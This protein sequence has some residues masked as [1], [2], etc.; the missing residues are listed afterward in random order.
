MS[1]TAR[2]YPD[3]A[4]FK[5]L[6]KRGNAVPVYRQVL[7]DTLT[8]VSAFE[9]LAGDSPHAFL[10]ESVV[11]GEKIARYSFVGAEPYMVFRAR[12]EAVELERPGGEAERCTSSDPLALLQ[13]LVERHRLVAVPGLPRFCGGA[14]GFAAYDAVRYFEHL[15]T[16]PPDTLGLPD[17]SFALYNRMLVFDHIDKTVR[18]VAVAF[19]EDRDADAAYDEAVRAVD[20]MVEALRT[21]T[22]AH[23]EDV[24]VPR[25]VER[26]VTS[27][28]DRAGFEAAVR[29]AKEYIRAGDV[30]QV[31]L[32]QRFSTETTAS[33]LDIYRVLRVVNPSPFLFLVRQDAGSAGG[34]VHL[35]GSSPEVMVRVEGGV[36]T[37]R[38][39][40]GT[41]PRGR[42]PRED[43][44]LARE[45]LADP[46]ER[47]E[48]VMLLDLGRNDVGRVARPGTVR[49]DER[50]I[51]ERFS[52]VM[53]IT[54]NVSGLLADGRDAFDALRA[55]LPAGTVSGAP[56]VRAM[57]IIDEL[58]P[59]R[60]G[61][62]AGAV[63]Y[64][65]F[66]GN[67][68]TCIALRTIVMQGRTAH[69]Q[70]GAGIVADSV[71]AREYEE[72]LNKARALLVAIE[73]AESLGG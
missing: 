14:V 25:A 41:R 55:A 43:E 45:L 56:K 72:T 21:P 19:A 10:L 61:P 28:F 9:K 38:P 1:G 23:A 24:A 6:L 39:I 46:K 65:D 58:E 51:I 54:S 5:R 47:A 26:P 16:P 59:V 7:A 22:P 67:M 60:R 42:T 37:V 70:A 36:V 62:Y 52:H 29:T 53:H 44:E 3:R 48:H 8:P 27:T 20:R 71:P 17:L 40:A 13:G 18:V 69:V 68:D 12:G 31:V 11:G 32:S 35:I 66:S 4:G 63:G 15:P 49:I 73:V 33:P 30:F 64:V 50:M 57:E 2:Y 34:G